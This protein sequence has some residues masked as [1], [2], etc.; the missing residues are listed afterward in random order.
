MSVKVFPHSLKFQIFYILR[1][2]ETLVS[3]TNGVYG[4]TILTA[5]ILPEGK[6]AIEKLTGYL[7]D[8]ATDFNA[9]SRILRCRQTAA[10]VSQATGKDFLFDSRLNELY[11]ETVDKFVAKIKDFLEEVRRGGYRNVLICTHG[12]VIAILTSLIVSGD[13]TTYNV[14]SLPRPGVLRVI[15]AG[16]VQ[17]LDFNP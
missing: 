1:H 8:V 16:K 5:E 10:I 17:D 2:G 7:K 3:Q 9:S 11:N 4:D 13:L 12:A 6:P 14:T 15:Q